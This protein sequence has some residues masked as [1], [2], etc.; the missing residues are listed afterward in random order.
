MLRWSYWSDRK[1]EI[2]DSASG[3]DHF[4]AKL[5]NGGHCGRRTQFK[6]QMGRTKVFLG[7][8]GPE[9]VRNDPH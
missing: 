1:P 4:T 6:K 5:G 7:E 3:L 2:S 8:D 9:S